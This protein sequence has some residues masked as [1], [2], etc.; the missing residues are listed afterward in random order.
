MIVL[1]GHENDIEELKKC[2]FCGS[3]TLISKD[4]DKNLQQ[5]NVGHLAMT[6]T[7]LCTLLIL[8][9]DLSRVNK[10]AILKAVKYLQNENGR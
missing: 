6:S 4:C 2:G 7:L 5:Y 9:D 8:G 3:R 1:S 10:P